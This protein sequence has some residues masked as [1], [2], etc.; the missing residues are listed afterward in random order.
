MISDF[1]SFSLVKKQL[2]TNMKESLFESIYIGSRL[3]ETKVNAYRHHSKEEA[4]AVVATI[5]DSIKRYKFDIINRDKNLDFMH[6]E[7]LDKKTSMYIIDKFLE[8]RSLIAVV[9]NRNNPNEELYVFS[10]MV[11]VRDRKKYI[12]L[13]VSMRSDG[14]V[15]AISWHGQTEMMHP[16]YRMAVDKS[17]DDN[18]YFYRKLFQNW[19]RVYNKFND[20]KMIDVLPNGPEDVTIVFE[21]PID[22]TEEWRK[23]FCKTVPKDYGYHYKDIEHNM[24]VEDDCVR[25]HLKIGRF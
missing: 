9:Q 25:L 14:V 24:K 22:D 21:H 18:R 16:D 23:N 12:Y 3:D 15:K 4:E 5:K 1:L 10:I 13:K 19:E 7:K 8:P 20:N 17:D 11:P 6:N 2:N